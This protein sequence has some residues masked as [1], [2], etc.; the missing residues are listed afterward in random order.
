MGA[1]SSWISGPGRGRWL[2]RAPHVAGGGTPTLQRPRPSR[3]IPGVRLSCR[4]AAA[5]APGPARGRPRAA[6][7]APRPPA[8]RAPCRR[9]ARP[10]SDTSSPFSS[11][12]DA[13]ADFRSNRTARTDCHGSSWRTS[14]VAHPD[15]VG[16]GVHAGAAEGQ[17]A[18]RRAAGRGRRS[19]PG[20]RRRKD[21]AGRGRLQR[22]ARRRPPTPT[23]T[24][25]GEREQQPHAGGARR[26]T[27]GGQRGPDT[28]SMVS[29]PEPSAADGRLAECRDVEITGTAQHEA[30]QARALPPVEQLRDD[31]WSIPVPIPHNP[32]RYNSIYAFALDGGGLGLIDTG[33][34][35]RRGAGP[36]SPA[37][38]PRSAATSTT[39]AA[40][41][42]PTCTSTTSGL[43]D[44]VREASGAW[45][46]MHPADATVVAGLNRSGRRRR[47]RHR[48][49]VPR[50]PGRRP[51]RGGRRRRPRREHG[52]VHPHGRARPAARGRRPRRLPRLAAARRPHARPHP[53]P[54]LLRRGGRAG[55][56]SP[57]TTCCRG[58]ARTSPPAPAGARDPLRDYLDSLAAVRDLD[59]AEVLPAHEWRFRGLADRVDALTAHHEHRLTELLAA[60]R[61]HPGLDAVAARRPPHLVAAVGAVRAADADLRRDR[62]RRPPAAAG[63]PRP[64]RRQRRAG[65][66]VDPGRPLTDDV[67]RRWPPGAAPRRRGWAARRLVCVD[68]PAG[69]GQDH[70]RRPAGRRPRRRRRAGAHGRPLRRLDAHRRRRPA[71][72]RRAAAAGRGPRPAPTTASTGHAGRFADEPVAVPVPA[73]AGRR[74][75]RQQPPARWTRGRRCASGWR[76]PRRCGW[77]A[78][79][80]ATART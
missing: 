61:A 55:C 36:R 4:R 37:G 53:R 74:G 27:G 31:L 40:C 78:G 42:S 5:A 77:P 43:A 21:H 64:R 76:R 1:G 62:D 50:R 3:V 9:P 72:R 75:L 46:A 33:W 14:E 19:R 16:V 65:A 63:Q 54:P 20:R 38:W 29:G 34:E 60:I 49:R 11:S 32:L 41:S 24:A 25:A 68:G 69:L 57:A 22:R 30:W 28:R 79:W 35:Q 12:S 2:V 73:G 23:T 26:D 66:D 18:A 13:Q 44:R 56:S 7:A 58:S 45:I 17:D 10:S 71:G 47:G 51:R 48:G 67:R 59:P 8:P 52:A 15:A 6:R 70:V 39:S 80:P